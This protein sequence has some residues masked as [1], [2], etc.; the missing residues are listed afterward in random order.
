MFRGII[1]GWHYIFKNNL[2]GRKTM[3]SPKNQ[4]RKNLKWSHG[5]A[6]ELPRERNMLK[7]NRI[8]IIAVFILGGCASIN[9]AELSEDNPA[10]AIVEVQMQRDNSIKNQIDLLA[11]NQFEAGDRKLND[12]IRGLE[13]NADEASI[14]KEL[15]QAKAYFIEAKTVASNRLVVP[16]RILAA[17]RASLE[18]EVRTSHDLTQR[19]EEIDE[20]LLDKTKK[21]TTVLSVE[22][23]SQ[24][25]KDYLDLEI[26]SVKNMRLK[27][28]R[29]IVQRAQEN[30]ALKIAPK[31]YRNA[32]ND[33]KAAENMIQQSPRNPVN[34]NKS[35]MSADKSAKLLS[36]V[37]GK[38]KGVAK[39]ASEEAALALVYQ[40]RKLG[41]LS[42]QA[43][44]SGN[45]VRLQALRDEVRKK[46]TNNE[47]EVYQQG[48]EIIIRLKQIDFKSGSAM[49]PSRSMSLLSK[50]NSAII[51][52][53]PS[54]VIVQGHT[55]STGKSHNNHILSVKRSQSVAKYL[56]SLDS[57]YNISS[58]GFGESQPIA[59][60][61]T[62]EGRAMNRRVD[63]VV[64]TSNQL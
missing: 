24:F 40:E 49:V 60:N 57:S 35:V 11:N 20:S 25:E 64:N 33:L 45:K 56:K 28:F 47:A 37:M 44:S 41:T 38:L 2:T 19:L 22:I 30:K 48:N 39:G 26:N 42:G 62:K 52:L 32:N 36:D 55:D 1:Q 59:N 14:L 4:M 54:T 10:D 53:H 34:Y 5:S 18:K 43:L 27:T 8:L 63:I 61:Q 21:F 31:S 23:L 17:R 29:E 7:I 51:K 50:V 9:Q 3:I 15:S 58:S 6:Y 12:A 46:F 16:N 13:S